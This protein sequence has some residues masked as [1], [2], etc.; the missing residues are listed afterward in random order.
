MQ[1]EDILEQIEEMLDKSASVPLSGGR[2]LVHVDKIMDLLKDLRMALP[3][4]FSEA[5]KVVS[6]RKKIIEIAEEEKAS[7]IRNAEERAAQLI[8]HE[9]I[10]R[11]AQQ[12][13]TEIVHA[14]QQQCKSIISSTQTHI[15]RQLAETEELLKHQLVDI[16]EARDAVRGTSRKRAVQ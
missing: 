6:D 15:D 7:I 13:A 11:Q 2:N 9:S 4:E 16:K 3:V 10:V 8:S 1:I 14:A 5:K 12:Q